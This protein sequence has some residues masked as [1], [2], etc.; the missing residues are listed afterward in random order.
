MKRLFALILA[1]LLLAG[2]ARSADIAQTPLE[3]KDGQATT[4]EGNLEG[5]FEEGPNADS[6]T[7]QRSEEIE[8]PVVDSP[9]SESSEDEAVSSFEDDND[10]N[11]AGEL[12]S[13]ENDA[14]SEGQSPEVEFVS[15]LSSVLSPLD[16]CKV[17]QT[18][19]IGYESKGF[20]HAS[21]IPHLGTVN[22]AIVAMDFENAPGS[23]SV[24]SKFGHIKGKL[25]DWSMNWSFGNM[26]YKVQMHDG[27]IRAPKGAEWYN[28]PECHGQGERKQTDAE[29]M[30]QIIEAIDPYYNLAGI[31]FIGV[32]VPRKA[33]EEFFFGIYGLKRMAT[34][35]G[36]QSFAAFGGLGAQE[37]VSLWDLWIHE[38]LHFQGFVGHG[39]G[40]GSGYGVMQNQWGPSKAI[41]LWEGFVATWYGQ[42]EVA[43]I[44]ANDLDNPVFAELDT[45]DSFGSGYE[46][47]VV[48]LS[49]EEVLVVEHREVF[50]SE[51][52]AYRVNIN[53]PTYRDDRGGRAADERNWWWYVREPDG[54]IPISD[55]VT[56]E[57][58]TVKRLGDGLVE[59]SK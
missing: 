19:R 29:S 57:G 30:A 54:N 46:G 43:C 47:I 12:Q 13:D 8:E 10:S 3:T 28:C 39:P 58:V 35:E 7:G 22:V 42:N 51:I 56:Y 2:C 37:G 18:S 41:N 1:A 48:K 25:E 4:A 11:E 59:L 6:E 38:I 49:N 45:I 21:G 27:W 55:S 24:A 23:G 53:T 17:K 9:K 26:N 5:E 36:T 32:I 34:D 44:D 20:P 33:N 14:D 31:D 16:T 52:L 50:G 40:N 15:N